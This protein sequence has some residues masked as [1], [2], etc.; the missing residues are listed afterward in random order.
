MPWVNSDKAIYLYIGLAGFIGANLRFMISVLTY[1]SDYFFPTGTLL[2]NYIGCFALG[3]FSQ[4]IGT[5]QLSLKMKTA[6]STGLIGSFTTFSAFSVETISLLQDGKMFIAFI[7]IMI[8]FIGG[9]LFAW[10]GYKI[11]RV[12]I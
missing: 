9:S 5:S 4:Y 8:S 11:G 7:Y 10:I 3:W 1:S 6:I 12:F 2:C